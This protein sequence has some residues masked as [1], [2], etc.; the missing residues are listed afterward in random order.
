MSDV[1][2]ELLRHK[3]INALRMAADEIERLTA[4]LQFIVVSW[5]ETGAANVA[6][7]A[8]NISRTDSPTEATD[9]E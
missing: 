8:L 7:K 5:P 3:A 2:P 1:S 9:D 4:A 6:R